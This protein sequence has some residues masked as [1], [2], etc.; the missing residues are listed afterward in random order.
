MRKEPDIV[1]ELREAEKLGLLEDKTNTV[2]GRSSAVLEKS[3]KKDDVPNV[4]ATGFVSTKDDIVLDEVSY[5]NE[6]FRG[7]IEQRIVG[8]VVTR[9]NRIVFCNK[10]ECELFGYS[11][12]SELIGRNVS[13]FIH[14]DDLQ[15]LLGL[16][17]RI[18]NGE[19]LVEPV[20]FRGLRKDGKDVLIEAF[21][22]FIPFE[23]EDALLSF[24]RDITAG[25]S[26]KYESNLFRVITENTSDLLAVTT[27]S[28]NPKYVYVSPSHEKIMGYKPE[29]LIGKPA[30][31]FVHPDDKKRLFSLAKKYIDLKMKGFFSGK[32]EEVVEHFEYRVRDKYGIWHYVDSTANLVEDN[33]IFVSKDVTERKRIE[34]KLK[35]SQRK[36]RILLDASHDMALLLDLDGTILDLNDAMAKSLG[37]DKEKMINTNIK[38]YLPSKVYESRQRIVKKV[39][40][41]KKPEETIDTRSGRWFDNK[42]Y[43]VLDENGEVTQ[44]AVFSREITEQRRVEETLKGLYLQTETLLNAAADGI[45]IVNKDFTVK[46]LN[47]T[48]VKLAGVKKEKAVGM[49]CSDMFKADFCGTENCSIV[50]A[51]K[52]KK[53]FHRETVRSR[54]DGE[55]IYCLE[56]VTPLKD[57][58]G[59]II[60]IIEDFRDISELKRIEEKLRES[61]EKF[62]IITS[63]AYDAIIMIDSDGNVSYWNKSAERIFGYKAEEILGKNLHYL[64]APKS[65]H[66]A[67]DKGFRKFKETGEG[68]A[69][70]RTLEL[71]GLKKDGTEILVELS[72]S[73]VKIKNKWHAIG[74]IRDITERKKIEKEIKI[75]D[76]AIKSSI[77]GIAITDSMGNIVYVNDSFLKMWR[78]D[79]PDEVIGKPIVSF[80]E[81]NENYRKVMNKLV[82]SGGWTGE[83]IG[84]RKDRTTF[85]VQLSINFVKDENNN[86]S[87]IFA[88]FV[89][90][91]EQKKAE[92]ELKR[93]QERIEKQNI[94][95][96]KLDKIKTNFLNITSHELRTPMS[97]IKGYTQMMLKGTLGKITDEQKKALNVVLRN[98][99][100]LDNLIRDI[101]DVSRLESGTMK[102]LPEQVDIKEIISQVT[103]TMQSF[104]D[105][106]KIQIKTMI[107]KDL[108][109]LFVDPERI[110]QVIINITNNA[111][112]FSPENSTIYIRVK[113]DKKDRILF[114]I[115]DFGKGIPKNKQKKIFETFYQ[116]DSGMD[117]KFGGAGLGLAISRGIILSH[118]GKIWVESKVG[119]GS[120]F[121]FTLPIKPVVDHEERFKE[122]DIFGLETNKEE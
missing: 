89:D 84:K 2:S 78:Y 110:K 80:W 7:L 86:I 56:V 91:T 112:K 114:E 109:K 12:P 79:R 20:I 36:L 32:K 8:V 44:I 117:R 13:E 59:N 105:T 75:R 118:G 42:F 101:L 66:E 92:E 24:H 98:I 108:P 73:S 94:Q 88:S 72:L 48:M 76:E 16:A 122:V 64:I 81:R 103:E 10:K 53:T 69:V 68:T 4:L 41:T 51:L 96:K 26:E 85:P 52:E 113:K 107:Q 30:L 6:L 31:D 83:L 15:I 21:A 39:Q 74:V 18:K 121:K 106:K 55:K 23:G 95:L 71:T 77:N 25:E 29:D 9:N 116:V 120:T 45:R 93:K 17:D 67:Y 14:R 28:L 99:N 119:K 33:I 102:F 87:N 104:A 50:K 22:I 65:L 27:F 70:G 19:K 40:K 61:E 3:Y 35:E 100:R 37:G 34:E 97:A 63:S 82:D 58:N 111:I 49:K 62:R 43:P 47:D 1:K 11:N 46:T 38:E 54:P 60:G 115:Q 5:S 57:A 90:I